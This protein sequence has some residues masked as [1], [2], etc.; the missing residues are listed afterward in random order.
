[1]ASYQA[2]YDE[3]Q[4]EENE[5]DTSSITDLYELYQSDFERGTYR[6]QK[7]GTYKIMEDITF[8]FNAGDMNSPNEGEMQWWPTSDQS[9][10]IGEWLC[11]FQ[12]DRIQSNRVDDW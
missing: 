7:S 11:V 9:L 5:E 6:I 10:V 4:A 2:A 3:E 1:M 12:S 8:D